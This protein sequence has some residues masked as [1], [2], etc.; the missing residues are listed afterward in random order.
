MS[1]EFD[2]GSDLEVPRFDWRS[3]VKNCRTCGEKNVSGRYVN[4]RKCR[5][6]NKVNED[7]RKR[8]KLQLQLALARTLAD[9]S[10]DENATFTKP[11][12]PLVGSDDAVGGV[13]RKAFSGAGANTSRKPKTTKTKAK[14]KVPVPLRDLGGTEKELAMLMMKRY[15]KHQARQRGV[16]SSPQAATDPNL[17]REYQTATALYG[18]IR[19]KCNASRKIH[20]SGFHT[21]VPT[22]E[23]DQKKRLDIVILDIRKI[24]RVLFEYVS[25]ISR[26]RPLPAPAPTP[27]HWQKTKDDSMYSATFKCACST[28]DPMFQPKGAYEALQWQRQRR[29][30]EKNG[31]RGE[32]NGTIKIAVEQDTTSHPF[33]IEGQRISVVIEHPG[34]EARPV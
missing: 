15:V 24:A 30:A 20:F 6:I 33:G 14:S 16:T 17:G 8:R 18:G 12:Q 31:E 11:A 34:P 3:F 19:G 9:G 26:T 7:E 29:K 5:K 10:G 32:C 13:E 2:N 25:L 28:F 23:I 4:C 1:S 27:N 22:P 21:I